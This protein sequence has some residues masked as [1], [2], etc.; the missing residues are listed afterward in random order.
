[1]AVALIES[2]DTHT[3]RRSADHPALVH[4]LPVHDAVPRDHHQLVVLADGLDRDAPARRLR[5]PGVDDALSA[6]DLEPIFA[7]VRSLAAPVLGHDEQGHDVREL[8]PHDHHADDDVLVAK[9]D[10]AHTIRRTAHRAHVG[11]VEP[12]RHALPGREH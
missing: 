7:D 12:D 8:L 5:D 4:A 6:A 2:H 1:D 3:L 10:A 9:T 11:F